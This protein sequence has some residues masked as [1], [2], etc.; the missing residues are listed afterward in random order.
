MPAESLGVRFLSCVEAGAQGLRAVT[1]CEPHSD[2][3]HKPQELSW[4]CV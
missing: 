4:G 3:K 1:D 2:I